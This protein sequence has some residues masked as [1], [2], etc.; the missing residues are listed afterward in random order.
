MSTPRPGTPGAIRE[1]PH[2]KESILESATVCPSCKHHLRF[3]DG[4]AALD[5]SGYTPLNI[6]GSFRNP[7][8]DADWEYSVVV[9]IRNER[10][11]EI[12]RKLI[13]VG[14]LGPNEQ[15]T[16]SLSLEMAPSK[17]KNSKSRTKH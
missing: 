6:E 4:A 13:G 17:S 7:A 14:A 11:Q 5:T 9:S 12:A 8:D 15:R 1:C 2:C 3:D 16:F 10:G